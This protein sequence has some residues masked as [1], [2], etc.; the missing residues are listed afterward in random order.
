MSR[1]VV[2]QSHDGGFVHWLA[3]TGGRLHGQNFWTG[4]MIMVR[5]D[6]TTLGAPASRRHKEDSRSLLRALTV[7]ILLLAFAPRPASAEDENIAKAVDE[8]KGHNF[9]DAAA[10]LGAA[11]PTEFNNPYLH[12]VM[13]NCMVHLRHKEAAIREYRIAYALQPD[14]QIG[15]YCKLCL[16]R[17]GIDAEGRKVRPQ[18]P[19]VVVAETKKAP[20]VP[21]P[22]SAAEMAELKAFPKDGSA[23]AKEREK[24]VAN[25]QDLMQ[26]K[27]RAS[28]APVPQAAGTN[29]YVRNYKET[30]GAPAAV[31]EKPPAAQAPAAKSDAPAATANKE[32]PKKK[33]W[34]MWWW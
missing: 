15:T 32:E 10:D 25:L 7:A 5:K 18:K 26:Q 1:R 9:E 20:P 2:D 34:G 31:S 11:L 30:K 33:K 21:E 27:K 14:G 3:D 13:A 22:P 12:Y 16:D 28:G 8:Y 4:E 29:L 23:A 19:A 6:I 24:S 17:F